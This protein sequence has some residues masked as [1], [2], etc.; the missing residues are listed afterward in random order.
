MPT[1]NRALS[2]GSIAGSSAISASAS[3]ARPFSARRAARAIDCAC[4]QPVMSL[5]HFF[6]AVLVPQTLDLCD[7]CRWHD[8]AD[9]IGIAL[10]TDRFPFLERVW[11]HRIHNETVG[12][13]R[14]DRLILER[15][16]LA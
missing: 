10:P 15:A 1:A 11:R 5:A 3:A 9:Q 6:R 16:D 2:A 4:A 12:L 13:H 14:G 7:H 8:L